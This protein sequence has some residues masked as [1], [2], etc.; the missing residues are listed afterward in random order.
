MSVVNQQSGAAASMKTSLLHASAFAVLGVSVRDNRQRI[1]ERAE[2][3]ALQ[4]DEALVG[5]ARAE[6][7]TPKSR[8]PA[9][10]GWLPGVSPR[11]AAQLADRV[12]TDPMSL[13]QEAGLPPLAHANLLAAAFA[14]VGPG[15]QADDVASFI[16]KLAGSVDSIDVDDVLRD[17]NEDRAVSGFPDLKGPEGIETELNERRRLFCTA[18]SEGLDRMESKALV[19]AMTQAVSRATQNGTVHAPT[20]IDD[21]VDRY[22]QRIQGLLAKEAEKATQVIAAARAAASSG[23]RAVAPLVDRLISITRSWFFIAHPIQLSNR[24]RG[25]SHE[26]SR[27]LGI[28]IRGLSIYLFNHHN[29]LSQSKRL[30]ALL[31]E[32]FDEQPELAEQAEEDAA[33]LERFAAEKQQSE[34][35]RKE[36]E[37]SITFTA[38]IGAVFKDTLSISPEGIAWK[39]RVYP[40]ERVTRIRWGGTRHSINGIPTGSIYSIAFGDENREEAIEIRREQT[41][42]T[43]VDKL[44]KAAGVRILVSMLNQ[45]GQGKQIA[46]GQVI[47]NDEGVFLPKRRFFGADERIHCKWTEMRAWSASGS[48]CFASIKEPKA[49]AALS[50]ISVSNVHVLEQAVTIFAKK[51]NVSMLSGIL[52]SR[53]AG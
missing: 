43:V 17:V 10:L 37:R 1:L 24:A 49:T 46:F 22:E 7:T 3:K 30:N 18:I 11:R 32:A 16:I 23:E 48:Y 9:E 35:E 38:E 27:D 40:L 51:P 42:S 6:L 41:Y 39:G 36:F 47:V 21:L 14:A 26:A 2:E 29:L 50:Y 5:K 45:L 33:A 28:E 4:G 19:G 53:A 44:W 13:W 34:A 20:L 8:L 12:L 31:I 15:H 25:I 52:S